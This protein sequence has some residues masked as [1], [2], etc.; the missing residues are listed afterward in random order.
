MTA[1]DCPFRAADSALA[2]WAADGRPLI[3]LVDFHAESNQEKEALGL[4]L[5][6]RATSVTGTHTHV[7]TADET[8][9]E[10]GTAYLTDAGMCGPAVGVLGREREPIIQRFRTSMPAKF[11]VA[12]WPVRL[13]GAVVQIDE[14]TGRALSIARINKIVE[15]PAS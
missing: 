7:Q 4:Y 11:P 2:A 15:K 14:A 8:I 10:H 5:A 1:I 13:C 3:V 12:N 6:G 9:L